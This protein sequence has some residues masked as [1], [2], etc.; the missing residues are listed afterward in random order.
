VRLLTYVGIEIPKKL[1]AS[2]EKVRRAIERDDFRSA[3][4]KKL[5][6]QAFFRARLD[7]DAR[8]LLQFVDFAGT[9]ACLALEVIE[10][11]EYDRS[12]FLRGA[13]VDESLAVDCR[14]ATGELVQTA[15]KPVRYL[16]PSRTE[17][18]VLDKPLCFDDRQ[19]EIHRLAPPLVLVGCAGSGKTALTL[20]KLRELSGEVLYVTQSPFLAESA[21]SLY[22]AHGYENERQSVDFLSYRKLLESVE[23][24]KGRAVTLKDFTGFFERN[25]ATLKF[26]TPH[27]LFEELRGVVT[28]SAEGPLDEAAYLALGVRQSIYRPEERQAVWAMFPKYTAWLAQAGLYDT[29]LLAHAHRAKATPRYDAVVVDEIQDLTNA[30]LGLVLALL[31]DRKSFVLCGDANQIVHPNFFSWARVKSLFY[32]RENEALEA[33]IHVLD[34][35]YRSSKT[36]CALANALLKV[37]N[38]RFGS[39]DRESTSLV[40]PVAE[41]EG[42]VAGLVKK[43]AVLRELDARTR[44][45]ANVAVL[46]LNDEHKA[47]ARQRFATPLVFSVHEAKGLEYESVIL[48]DLVSSERAA[49]RDVAE[50][51]TSADIDA[52]G[53]TYARARD[54]GDKSLE[55]YK[56]YVNAL[57]VALTRAVETIYVV[58][59]DVTHPLFALLRVP[60]SED[61]S[62]FTAKT[63]TL[64][65]WQRE[66]RKLELQGKQEQADAIRR[67]IL[68]QSPVPWP[69]F[70][71]RGLDEIVEKVFAPRSIFTKSKQ[72]LHDFAAFHRMTPLAEAIETRTDLRPAKTYPKAIEPALHRFYPM[73]ES[74]DHARVFADVARYGLEHRNQMSLTPL[75]MA[76]AAGNVPLVE[77]L[78]ERGARVDAVDA[79]GRMPLHWALQAAFASP[80][81]ASE[82]FGALY[83]L[84]CPTGLDLEVDGRLMRLNRTQGEF[85]VLAS[86]IALLHELYA[87]PGSRYR[88]FS[89]T[90]LDDKALAAFPRSVVPE[91]RRRRTYWNGVLARAE[92]D[93]LYRPARKLWRRERLGR[94][95]PSSTACL[96]VVDDQGNEAFRP[97]PELLRMPMLDRLARH[98]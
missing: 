18:H 88:G 36:V 42:R 14:D 8:L 29:N 9:R 31:K 63:S 11:H 45:S 90:M 80:S 77:A 20:T 17:F 75:M 73:Y 76:A 78:L 2:F 34:A 68:R 12:R 71:E 51:V 25:R 53:L 37:K 59:S 56:F 85:F 47:E 97:L 3:D 93:G 83:E 27:A 6:N 4:V 84:L 64:E 48:Y 54:K 39:V 86:M 28:A 49:Y 94:Y 67:T 46:V 62:G 19:A 16:H 91:E 70:H 89:A 33:P 13:K 7:Y 15:T 79:F 81:F 96:R 55:A 98:T 50:G 5:H 30:E 26:A 22:Y 52:E 41:L 10:R 92:I 69:V 38:A 23:V 72:Q 61:V 57:Y 95:V 32:S 74:D 66:A 58:E 44:A 87:E 40:R 65:D 35:N 82:A 60:F 24:P 1:A 21:A 43:D